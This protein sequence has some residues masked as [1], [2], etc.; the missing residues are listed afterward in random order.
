MVESAKGYEAR[1]FA[2]FDR[3]PSQL[4]RKEKRFVLS[5]LGKNARSRTY[6]GAFVWLDEAMV[7]NPCFNVEGPTGPLEMS[8]ENVVAQ[9]LPCTRTPVRTSHTPQNRRA[10][11]QKSLC[12]RRAQVLLQGYLPIV[13]LL[14]RLDTHIPYMP[15]FV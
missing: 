3:I 4:M 12:S 15:W 14:R 7:V 10:I 2:V 13:Y 6:E 9:M 5:S 11:T 8:A 1:V